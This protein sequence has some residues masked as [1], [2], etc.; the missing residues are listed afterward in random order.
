MR[1]VISRSHLHNQ[2]N[3]SQPPFYADRILWPIIETAYVKGV[4]KMFTL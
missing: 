1:L 3:G 4:E 2:N